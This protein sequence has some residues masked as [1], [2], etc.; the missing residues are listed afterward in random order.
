[1]VQEHAVDRVDVIRGEDAGIPMVA[2]VASVRVPR[3]AATAFTTSLPEN[4]LRSAARAS[5]FLKE[6]LYD[7]TYVRRV[8]C[9]GYTLSPKHFGELFSGRSMLRQSSRRGAPKILIPSRST[10]RR[11]RFEN[12]GR[13]G[14]RPRSLRHG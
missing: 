3:A 2:F 7:L 1:V 14:K 11:A 10:Y 6:I 8:A 13:S 4:V 5:R 9:C 12:Y